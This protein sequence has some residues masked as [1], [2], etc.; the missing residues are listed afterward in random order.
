MKAKILLG[1]AILA[2]FV[3]GALIRAYVVPGHLPGQTTAAIGQAPAQAASQAPVA[4]DPQYA[5][6]QN[7]QAQYSQQQDAQPEYSQPQDTQ[8]QYS[9]PQYTQYSDPAPAQVQSHQSL[10]HQA[11]IVGGSAAAGTAIGAVAGGGK[12]AAVGAVSGG[13]AGLAYDLLTKNR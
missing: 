5:E 9:Q 4:T 2:A 7:A 1:A 3:G 8:Q 10:K 6:P 11:L 13:I 12:G